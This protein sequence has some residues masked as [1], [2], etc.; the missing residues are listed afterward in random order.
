[1]HVSP[2]ACGNEDQGEDSR[3]TA[4]AGVAVK[5]KGN[6]LLTGVSSADTDTQAQQTELTDGPA[7]AVF[8]IGKGRAANAPS[9]KRFRH[10]GTAMPRRRTRTKW[11][12]VGTCSRGTS[13][14]HTPM[15][16]QG[17][18]LGTRLPG[19][20][21]RAMPLLADTGGACTAIS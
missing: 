9:P 3:C 17:T 12:R 18:A 14:D 6:F 20:R 8:A 5:V 11:I 7:R 1:M 4:L 10:G 21:P 19:R 15:T 2:N 13:D 16:S